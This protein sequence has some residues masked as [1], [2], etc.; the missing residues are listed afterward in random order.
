MK[1]RLC[2]PAWDCGWCCSLAPRC[3]FRLSDIDMG[4]SNSRITNSSSKGWTTSH[5]HRLICALVKKQVD[6]DEDTLSSATLS[7][8]TL[9]AFLFS[10]RLKFLIASRSPIVV[11]ASLQAWKAGK[12]RLLQPLTSPFSLV[13]AVP[14][15]SWKGIGL[16][17]RKCTPGI[18]CSCRE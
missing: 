11:I 2:G 3:P 8:G 17:A 15:L 5:F 4:S 12:R 14:W 7:V 13:K 6:A 10:K 18:F 1:R 16:F 9:Q